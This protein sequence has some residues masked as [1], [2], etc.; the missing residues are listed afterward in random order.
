MPDKERIAI[1]IDG[2][3]FY[4]YLKDKEILSYNERHAKWLYDKINEYSRQEFNFY[5]S[6]LSEENFFRLIYNSDT[7][8]NRQLKDAAIY[9]I[10]NKNLN[11]N[12]EII[13]ESIKSKGY[14]IESHLFLRELYLSSDPTGSYY[15]DNGLHRSLALAVL[16]LNQEIKYFPVP[17]IMVLKIKN[18]LIGIF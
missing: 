1:Y 11:N 10:D 15:I 17:V 6:N 13:K 5:K 4:H 12:T 3:N 16:F 7:L 2:S 9:Y 18:D 8:K 14:D